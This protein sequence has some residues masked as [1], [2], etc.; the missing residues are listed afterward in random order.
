MVFK[1]GFASPS[2]RASTYCRQTFEKHF[3]VE[4][5]FKVEQ[6]TSGGKAQQDWCGVEAQVGEQRL[7]FVHNECE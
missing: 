2:F 3:E 4:Q 7:G 5:S 1:H 6:R